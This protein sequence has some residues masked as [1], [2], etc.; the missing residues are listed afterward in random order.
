M[1]RQ[2]MTMPALAKASGIPLVSVERYVNGKRDIPMG[3]FPALC[4]ALGVTV[5]EMVTRVEGALAAED[6]AATSRGGGA[7]RRRGLG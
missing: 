5:P 4:E 3:K 1:G 6:P 2:R 7:A